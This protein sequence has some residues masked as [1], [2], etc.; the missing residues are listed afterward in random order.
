MSATLGGGLGERLAALLG[1]VHPPATERPGVSQ[2]PAQ[3]LT[4]ELPHPPSPHR[5]DVGQTA[6]QL[7]MQ[8]PHTSAP[9]RFGGGGSAHATAEAALVVGRGPDSSRRADA[10]GENGMVVDIEGASLAREDGVLAEDGALPGDARPCSGQVGDVPRQAA[11]LI[12]SKGR[13]FPVTIR[14]LGPPGT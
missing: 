14:Y 12:V 1:R 3:L 13:S 4:P 8:L 7:L 6:T 2:I 5:P 10:D 9:T 11:P